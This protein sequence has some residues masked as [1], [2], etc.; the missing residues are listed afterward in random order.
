VSWWKKGINKK[1]CYISP[2]CPEAPHRRIC[3]KFGAAVGDADVIT[4]TN[5]FGDPS[6]GVY[7]V[8]VENCHLPLTKPVAVNT[9]LALPCSPWLDCMVLRPM[10]YQYFKSIRQQSFQY[11]CRQNKQTELTQ[12]MK[13]TLILFGWEASVIS[14]SSPSVNC[15]C[16]TRQLQTSD[17]FNDYCKKLNSLKHLVRTT[18]GELHN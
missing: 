6:R 5:F 14:T 4:C 1:N 7:S 11:S 12:V 8:G 16:H 3:T 10:F 17:C 9:G 2:I 13:P 15:I 18:V